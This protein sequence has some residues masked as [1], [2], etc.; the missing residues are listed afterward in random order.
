MESVGGAENPNW[1]ERM[2]TGTGPEDLADR[3]LGGGAT[4]AE[5]VGGADLRAAADA[6]EKKS[7]CGKAAVSSGE[8][9]STQDPT[10][11]T[12][13]LWKLRVNVGAGGALKLRRR[14]PPPRP[15][16]PRKL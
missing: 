7:D 1:T 9:G 13:C 14:S 2:P 10:G 11:Q 6:E 3:R 4:A 5:V 15:A 16:S 12:G 8:L